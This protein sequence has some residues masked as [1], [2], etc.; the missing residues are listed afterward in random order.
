[1]IGDGAGD[2]LNGGEGRD[3]LLGCNYT[4]PTDKCHTDY[5]GN[6]TLKGGP[7]IDSLEGQY[8][9][10]ILEGG[11]D[12]NLDWLSGGEGDDTLVGGP[13]PKWALTGTFERLD[14]GSGSD[15]L[16]GG[17]GPDRIDGGSGPD[18]FYGGERADAIHSLPDGEI[19]RIN[20]GP[21]NDTVRRYEPG[22][23]VINVNCET[24]NPY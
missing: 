2:V 14:G 3:I 6:D 7:G 11:S 16:R 5:D 1:M 17:P 20:C 13:N 10:D 19:D 12:Y 21:G 24:L 9:N 18:A 8:G 15:T 4:E 23:D 22:V